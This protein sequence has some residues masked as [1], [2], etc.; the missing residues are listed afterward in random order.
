MPSIDFAEVRARIRMAQVLELAGFVAVARMGDQVRG[1]CPVHGSS[2]PRS[3]SFLA[4]LT[5]N[6]FRCFRCGAAGNQLDLWAAISKLPLPEAAAD[7]CARLGMN[8]PLLRR[9]HQ[10]D[11]HL[12]RTE[13]RNT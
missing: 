12:H 8:T 13:K 10:H 6:M 7:L 3:R 9:G 4:N 1:P 11:S 5:R 2:S